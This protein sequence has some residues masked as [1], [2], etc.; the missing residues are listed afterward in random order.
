AEGIGEPSGMQSSL[1]AWDVAAGK[2]AWQIPT[3]V[4]GGV[5]ATAGN[6]V[7]QGTA[8][9]RLVAF[10]ADTGA[11]IWEA[12]LG[13]SI[14]AAPATYAIDGKQY[15]SVLA[16]WGGAGG[17]YVANPAG[18]YKAEGRVYTFTLDG[19]RDYPPVR[20]AERPPLVPIEHT[21]TPERIAQG[22]AVFN[23]LC[24]MCHG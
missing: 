7:F 23:R 2:R 15:V 21:A 22:D 13:I 16:G 19:S 1:L 12:P 4:G 6:L 11:Q 5:L 14:M 17:L 8:D 24:S 10:A 9:G 18:T 20:S 3:L